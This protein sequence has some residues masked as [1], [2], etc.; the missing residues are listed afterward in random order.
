MS[1]YM[2]QAIFER[3]AIVKALHLPGS[4]KHTAEFLDSRAGHKHA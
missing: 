4:K 1:L 2:V 3:L